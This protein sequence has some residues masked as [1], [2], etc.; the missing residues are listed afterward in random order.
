[1]GEGR[2]KWKGKEYFSTGEAAEIC[3]VSQQ[4]IIRHFDSGRIRG[5]RVPGSRFRRIP[6]EE[7]LRFLR[8]NDMRTDVLEHPALRVLVVDDDQSF[9][10]RLT[11]HL[12]DRGTTLNAR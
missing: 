10:D 9:L 12:A 1:M 2:Q 3:C 6:R 4:T 11:S 7:L 5:H 8:D